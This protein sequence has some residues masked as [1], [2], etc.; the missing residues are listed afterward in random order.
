MIVTFYSYKGGVGRTLALANIACFLAEDQEHPQRVLVWDFD[1]E[2]PGL[3]GL[4]RPKKPVK[5]G[6]VDMAYEFANMGD[7]PDLDQY[8]YTSQVHGIDVLPAG[9]VDASY[10]EKLQSIDWLRFFDSDPTDAGPFFGRL[11]EELSGEKHA[12]DYVLI[13]SR[14]GLNDQAGISTQVLPNL[15]VVLFRLTDQNLDGLEYLLPVMKGQLATREK[16]V[17]FLPVASQVGSAAARGMVRE[18]DRAVQIFGGE[19]EYIRFDE[20]LTGREE[21]LCL[22]QRQESMWPQPPIVDDYRRVAGEI[23][24]HNPE[25]TRI[26]VQNLWDRIGEGDVTSCWPAARQ[27]VKRRPRLEEAWD[28]LASLVRH[29]PASTR[30]EADETVSEVLRDDEAN[31]HALMWKAQSQMERARGPDSDELRT[32]RKLLMKAWEHVSEAQRQRTCL[33]LYAVASCL[34]E[35]SEGVH[36]VQKARCA[37]PDNLEVRLKLASLHVRMG[38]DHFAEAARE[39]DELPDHVGERKYKPLAY[40]KAFFGDQEGAVAALESCSRL[41]ALAR[42]HM[43]LILGEKQKALDLGEQQLP[44]R[45]RV[46]AYY[47]WIEFLVCAEEFERALSLAEQVTGEGEPR[48]DPAGALAELARY[49]RGGGEKPQEKQVI[50]SWE[51][52]ESWDFTELLLFRERCKRENS[53]YV[54][55]LAIIEDLIRWHTLWSLR[56]GSHALTAWGPLAWSRR[57]RLGRRRLRPP[58]RGL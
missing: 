20:E 57:V 32:A 46:S 25:D 37:S 5:R 15:L 53:E 30:E 2:A 14:T 9:Q 38:A 1:L 29:V 24:S 47:N 42:C 27:L 28:I 10:C 56:F 34:G 4:F 18:R 41:R 22:R 13:D 33:A 19:I 26:Q 58:K 49:L 36:W 12:Y 45:K 52:V 44:A 16:E 35:L 50:K 51:N 43:H 40:L 31:V 17:G 21:L 23:R 3:Y 6:F 8:I 55:Q 7:V 39:L 54:E 48:E 11:A